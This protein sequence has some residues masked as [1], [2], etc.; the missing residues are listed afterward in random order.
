MLARRELGDYSLF[1]NMSI[2][3]ARQTGLAAA[4]LASLL[5][6]ETP[7]RAQSGT[8]YAGTAKGGQSINVDLRSIRQV[9]PE[10]LDFKYF[11]G[12]IGIYAQANCQG[13]YWVTFPERQINRP[14]SGATQRMMDKVCSYLE[15]GAMPPAQG[16]R[17]ALVFDP[18][19]NVRATPNGPVLCSIRSRQV[20]NVYG[21]SGRWYETDYC[22]GNG[23]IHEAQLRF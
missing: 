16:P 15:G 10:S 4:C 21:K 2:R 13:G 7:S 18:P 9:S 14:Q 12:G 5:S 20:I 11:L 23:Y 22:G 17:R 1:V 6:L 19:S 8:F 3:R